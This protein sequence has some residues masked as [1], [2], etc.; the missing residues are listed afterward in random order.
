MEPI[1]QAAYDG[2]EAEVIRLVTQEDI[3]M[4]TWVEDDEVWVDGE[5]LLGCTP[6]MLAAWRGHDAVVARLLWHWGQ[7]S[8]WVK[9]GGG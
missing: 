3:D 1:H 8:M 2:N 4:D 5:R 6:L 7:M 9:I